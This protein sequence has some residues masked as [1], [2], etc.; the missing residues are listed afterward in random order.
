MNKSTE[1]KNITIISEDTSITGDINLHHDLEIN[2]TFNSGIVESLGNII[3]GRNGVLN[4]R[5]I[6]AH[7][8]IVEGKVVGDLSVVDSVE[9][10]DSSIFEGNISTK[11]L[12]ISEGAFFCELTNMESEQKN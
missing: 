6:K 12:V 8:M 1:I 5:E 2:G 7:N 4:S 11:N 9:L 3:V 10:R